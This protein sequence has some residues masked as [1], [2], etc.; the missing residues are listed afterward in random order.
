MVAEAKEALSSLLLKSG[1]PLEIFH[2]ALS[3]K[4][5]LLWSHPVTA[6]AMTAGECV[7]REIIRAV[8][9]AAVN[10]ACAEM[11][12]KCRR[13]AKYAMDFKGRDEFLVRCVYQFR[14]VRPVDFHSFFVPRRQMFSN[15]TRA[16]SPMGCGA[17]CREASTLRKRTTHRKRPDDVLYELGGGFIS[18]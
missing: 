15:R 14:H 10:D 11:R 16:L 1:Q 13:Y 7:R 6:A 5:E 2:H 4:R 9:V 3:T 17:P 18:A 8:A 12:E